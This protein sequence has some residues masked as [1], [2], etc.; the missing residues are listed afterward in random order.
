M[1]KQTKTREAGDPTG[2]DVMYVTWEEFEEGSRDIARQVARF[3]REEKM[4]FSG[5]HGVPRG[6]LV[7]AV[8][9][10]YLLGIPLAQAIGERTLVVDDSSVTGATLRRLCEPHRNRAA[11][12]VHKPDSSAFVPDFTYKTTSRI[13]NYPWEA[14]DDRN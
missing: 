3:M 14:H 9:L 8:R 6:G 11:V 5:I 13:V 2:E 1:R 4:R 12:F 10:S 7:L